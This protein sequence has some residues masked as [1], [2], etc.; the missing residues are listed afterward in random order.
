MASEVGM[1]STPEPVTTRAVASVIADRG[2][3]SRTSEAFMNG[4][5]SA[6]PCSTRPA[7]TR[8]KEGARTTRRAPR[9]PAASIINNTLRLPMRS[10]RRP[11]SGAKAA[12][13]M[14]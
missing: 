5:P 9:T 12:D 11:R 7:M 6:M 13:P 10:P 3:M 8:P 2:K 4:M 1:D 14:A